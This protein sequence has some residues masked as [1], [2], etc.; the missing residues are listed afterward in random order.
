MEGPDENLGDV[1]LENFLK[2]L[3]QL[4]KVI[5][6][7]DEE[8]GKGKKTSRLAVVELSHNS[9]AT[10][11]LEIRPRQKFEDLT[12]KIYKRFY[13]LAK[14]IASLTEP[15]EDNFYIINEFYK[16]FNP[17]GNRIK[18][19]TIGINKE[20]VSLTRSMKK[21]LE[22]LLKNNALTYFTSVEG[23]LEEI[24]V[25]N[26]KNRFRIFLDKGYSGSIT[27]QF[28]EDKFKE[29]T[30]ALKKRVSVKGTGR[31]TRG[32]T[33]PNLIIVD[34]ITVFPNEKE[35]LPLQKFTGIF[36]NVTGDLSSEDFVNKIREEEW[37]EE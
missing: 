15:K 1:D 24:N 12:D 30:E 2:E 17:I 35:Y 18:K 3:E 19:V 4:K 23:L 5:S 9:P 8:I 22:E 26:K 14:N 27:C 11:A 21:Y 32:Q 10:V 13:D 36:P 29:A 16:L 37:G 20:N 25:H 6:S 34:E 28:P 7:I 33:F 31:F